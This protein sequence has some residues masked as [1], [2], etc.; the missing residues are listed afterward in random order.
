MSYVRLSMY[1]KQQ[2]AAMQLYKVKPKNP[3]YF[4]AVM[5]AVLQATSSSPTSSSGGESSAQGAIMLQ[6][7]ERMIDKMAK[8][9]KVEQEQETQLYLMVLELQHKFREALGVLEGPLGRKLEETSSFVNLVPSRKLEYLKK[10]EMWRG[11]N[12]L[13][14]QMLLK[15]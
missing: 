12:A 11:V 1:K 2:Q 9:K 5:S 6:L 4:W 8:E 3:Y 10:L 14:K 13:S 7:A 15:R